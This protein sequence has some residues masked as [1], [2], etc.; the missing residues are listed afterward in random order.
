MFIRV[1]ILII[2]NASICGSFDFKVNYRHAS[3]QSRIR[4]GSTASSSFLPE[5]NGDVSYET[6]ADSSKSFKSMRD[7]LDKDFVGIAL[8]AFVG[9]AAEPL[10]AIVDAM[11]VGRCG[12]IDQAGM[13]IAI[14]AQ[15][16]IAKL[17]NDPLLKTSTSLV[18]GKAGDDLSAAVATAIAIGVIIGVMQSLGF[19]FFGSQILSFM[20]VSQASDMRKPALSYLKWRAVGIPAATLG[21]VTNGIFRGRGDTKTP[22]YFTAMGNLINILLDPILI[23]N[24][25]MGCAGAGA[26]AAISQ[27]ISA[28]PLIYLL[29]KSIP[30]NIFGREKGFFRKAIIAYTTAG[31][32]ILLRTIAKIS[33]YTVTSS[34]A[35]RLGTI[36]MA[37]YSL[38]FNLGFA[39]SQLLE[40]ISIAAQA[41]I[42]RDIPLDTPRKKAATAHVITRGMQSAIVISALLAGV[43]VYNQENVLNSMTKSPEVRAAARAVMPVV[44]ATQIFKGL[45]YSTGGILLGGLDWLYSTLGMGIA[46]SLCIGVVFGLPTTLY[47][48]WV[49]L[50]TFMG[51]QVIT[52]GWRLLSGK[53]PW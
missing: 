30:F 48:I 8:P 42:A 34:A 43:T 23:F 50:A 26:A 49:A 46:S 13:G 35:A 3:K 6:G 1:V 25:G 9:L 14:S 41:L 32:L 17:Y 39:T 12:A 16:S 24:C 19:L 33:A 20:G 7:R 29:N 10:A 22:L 4:L 31:G 21:L 38:T 51:A 11:Y 15:Y 40:S 2:F 47:T 18:A 45:S 36:P 5:K 37:A 28:I 44:L 53:G 52:A 27:W